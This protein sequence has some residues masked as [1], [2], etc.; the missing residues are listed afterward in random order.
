MDMDAVIIEA[1]F[2]LE[3]PYHPNGHFVCLRFIDTEPSHPK[4][5]QMISEFNQN[6][7]VLL[8]S[9]KY[10]SKKITKDTNLEHLNITWH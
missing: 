9:Y 4:L 8:I 1:E 5:K 10:D 2:Q 7:D 6:S 3:S